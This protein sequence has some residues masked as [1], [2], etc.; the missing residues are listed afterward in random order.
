MKHD[1]NSG[2]VFMMHV[3]QQTHF[4]IC[5]L[6]MNCRL[7]W[8]S[9]LLYCYF[10]LSL[11][12]IWWATHNKQSCQY[13]TS[14][15]PQR[16]KAQQHLCKHCATVRGLKQTASS[17]LQAHAHYEHAHQCHVHVVIH[18]TLLCTGS[19]AL[20]AVINT[21]AN[22]CHVHVV[23]HVTLLCTGSQALRAVIN[24]QATCHW[25]ISVAV[26]SLERLP[27]Q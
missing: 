1:G 3:F 21:Q 13:N 16:H 24:T 26:T 25:D 2:Y 15:Q 8:S 27:Y 4:A 6:R 18:V 14:W 10:H 11:F 19:Q 20:R 7:K 12:V 23:I 17:Q 9:Q 5:T 22:Q